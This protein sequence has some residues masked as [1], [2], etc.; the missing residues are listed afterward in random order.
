MIERPITFPGKKDDD[1][2]ILFVRKYWI[3]Y[4]FIALFACLVISIPFI[5]VLSFLFNASLTNMQVEYA[6]IILSIYFLILLGL[7][8]YAFVDYYLD[9][10][11]LTQDRVV[12]VRQNGFFN[13][14]ID[15]VYYKD[16]DEVGVD[17]KGFL[18]STFN[19]GDLVLHPGND[20]AVLTVDG[21]HEPHKVA[22]LIMDKHK[23]FYHNKEE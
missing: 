23:E 15:E 22:R 9:I 14:Q 11:I 17:V 8:L 16:V 19:Y 6:T 21:I 1:E 7:V 20:L 3:K 4:F 10:F 18:K 5:L 2:I 12:F 13:R